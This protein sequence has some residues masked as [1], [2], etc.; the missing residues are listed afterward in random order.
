[1]STPKITYGL[2]AKNSSHSFS[3]SYFTQKFKELNF[4]NCQYCNFDLD[5]ISTFKALINAD[6]TIK[7]LNVTIPYKQEIIPYLDGLSKEA[8]QIGAVNTIK[9]ENGKLIGYNTDV[10]GFEQSLK[11][12]FKNTNQKALIL[13]WGGASKAVKFVLTKLGFDITIVSRN[14]TN[15]EFLSYKQLTKTLIEQTKL[16]VNCTPLGTFPNVDNCP[17]IPYQYLNKNHVLFD[18]IYNPPVTK[19]LQYG[20]DCGAK[21]KNGADMLKLQAEKSWEIW[22]A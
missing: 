7:G 20:N 11:T 13:G 16:I 14:P 18:L 17:D 12:L 9:I 10:Y 19:F 5:D 21:I 15:N 4:E 2:I 6:K 3:K 8:Q 1:M 22:N